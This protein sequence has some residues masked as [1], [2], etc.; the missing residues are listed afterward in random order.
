MATIYGTGDV[1]EV[2]IRLE[3]NHT[4]ESTIEKYDQS[5]IELMLNTTGPVSID[6]AS[7]DF[8]LIGGKDYTAAYTDR[9][10]GESWQEII[11]AD[12]NRTLRLIVNE[13]SVIVRITPTPDVLGMLSLGMSV[14][15]IILSI[16][17]FYYVDKRTPK[18]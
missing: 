12:E 18:E 14:S 13:S 8:V 1:I 11:E 17:I 3:S 5:G 16:V 10:S 2:G 7:G 9:N 15:V 6:V 4:W